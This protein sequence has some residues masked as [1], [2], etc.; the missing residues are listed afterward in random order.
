MKSAGWDGITIPEHE[1][2]TRRS[3]FRRKKEV[4][5]QKRKKKED[6]NEVKPD[7]NLNKNS[8][9]LIVISLVQQEVV[10]SHKLLENVYEQENPFRLKE[11]NLLQK[12]T[13]IT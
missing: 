8:Q 11:D 3:Q 1:V 13:A 5:E 9:S 7:K 10:L 4:A 12:K 2:I 6:T